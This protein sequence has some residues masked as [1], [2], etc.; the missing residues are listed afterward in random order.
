MLSIS[1]VINCHPANLVTKCVQTDITYEE[2]RLGSVRSAM[3]T[4]HGKLCYH[5]TPRFQ[6]TVSLVLQSVESEKLQFVVVT[7][8]IISTQIPLISAQPSSMKCSAVGHGLWRG[9][10]RLCEVSDARTQRIMAIGVVIPPDSFKH[11]LCYWYYR[12]QKA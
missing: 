8:G 2:V 6:A 3:R 1:Y 11:H 5:S 7:Y 9:W 4:D 12:E 10:V